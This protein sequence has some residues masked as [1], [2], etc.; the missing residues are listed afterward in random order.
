MDKTWEVYPLVQPSNPVEVRFYFT[1]S[2]LD[3]VRTKLQ[4]NGF[5]G[6]YN[7]DSMSF[8]KITNNTKKRHS[9]IDSLQP[10]DIREY[11]NGLSPDL[12]TWK[13]GSQNSNTYYACLLTDHFSGGGGGSGASGLTPLVIENCQLKTELDRDQIVFAW[14]T[15]NQTYINLALEKLNNTEFQLVNTATYDYAQQKIYL[16]KSAFPNSGHSYFR[17]RILTNNYNIIYSN[18]VEL[19]Y[20]HSPRQIYTFQNQVNQETILFNTSNSVSTITLLNEIGK[21]LFTIKLSPNEKKNLNYILKPGIY[22][23]NTESNQTPIKP[24]KIIIH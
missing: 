17:L 16:H 9:P 22:F 12:Y 8:Y 11:K 18:I 3:S 19:N 5:Y 10:S 20:Q 23:L 15:F 1:K 13:L 7:P 2:D 6:A 21:A 24:I 14:N 4:N